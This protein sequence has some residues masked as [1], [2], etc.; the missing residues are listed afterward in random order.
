MFTP[1][2]FTGAAPCSAEHAAHHYPKVSRALGESATVVAVPIVAERR[3]DAQRSTGRHQSVLQQQADAEQHLQLVRGSRG[4]GAGRGGRVARAVAGSRLAV[5][6]RLEGLA[7][8][9][10]QQTV[11]EWLVV[12]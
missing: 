3:V 5:R 1:M 11:D 6:R 9:A 7:I 10:R 4:A 12:G 8:D 2:W